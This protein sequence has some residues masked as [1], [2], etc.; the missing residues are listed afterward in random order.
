[1][2]NALDRIQGLMEIY[3]NEADQRKTL[4]TFQSEILSR[5]VRLYKEPIVLFNGMV[6]VLKH[7]NFGSL[8]VEKLI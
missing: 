8:V 7:I 5:Y 1:M 3:A 2:P 6:R 4:T